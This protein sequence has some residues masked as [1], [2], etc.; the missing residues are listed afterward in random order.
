M[1]AT[2]EPPYGR[3]GWWYCRDRDWISSPI[4]RFIQ[5]GK[6]QSKR[7]GLL[8]AGFFDGSINTFKDCNKE[9]ENFLKPI[10]HNCF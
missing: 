8:K 7:W 3:F 6:E 1:K 2:G 10:R 9:Y 5:Q 4:Q